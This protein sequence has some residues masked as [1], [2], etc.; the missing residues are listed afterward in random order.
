MYGSAQKTKKTK[1]IDF[2][3]QLLFFYFLIDFDYPLYYLDTNIFTI[4]S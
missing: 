1:K 3:L 4:L 2:S